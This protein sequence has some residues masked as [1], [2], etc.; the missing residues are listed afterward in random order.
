MTA[1]LALVTG[2]SSGIGEAFARELC[3]RGFGLVVVA[4]R[5][6]R[7]ESLRT[8]L[9]DATIDLLVADL[10]SEEGV[11][12]VARRL[13]LG[14]IDL[15]VNNAGAGYR[16]R[17]ADQSDE[18]IKTLARLNFET[19]M[20]LVRAA[21]PAMIAKG[22]GAIVN[23]VSMS[24]FQPVPYLNV[25]AATKTG[26]L[27]FTEALSDELEGTG[28]RLQALC[29]GNIPTEF[30]ALAGTKGSAFDKTPA[31]PASDVVRHS[32][33]AVLSEGGRTLQIPGRMDQASVFAQRFL[34]RS[35]GRSVAGRMM[36]L[37]HAQ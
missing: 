10:S 29:P 7:L 5:R 37:D 32:L 22:A 15:F 16:G 18:S 13:S 26:L 36:K 6:E 1:K 21:L 31:M 14:G 9:G 23:V 12:A 35:L 28:V 11:A 25:Y 19:P 8:A 27:S 24:A 34:P 17:L 30:Q 2:A 3:V 20:R 4:R 33:N